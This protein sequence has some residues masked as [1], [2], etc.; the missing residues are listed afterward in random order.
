MYLDSAP[1]A[2]GIDAK[3]RR[4]KKDDLRDRAVLE[5]VQ[6]IVVADLRRILSSG[7]ILSR[8]IATSAASV[9]SL[10]SVERVPSD[11]SYIQGQEKLT[12]IP[13]GELVMQLVMLIYESA[14]AFST[15]NT[16]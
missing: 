11:P 3:P 10:E 7:H 12:F 14:E 2:P 15:R 8:H 6:K 13:K 16:V 9:P 5:R 1:R 4:S